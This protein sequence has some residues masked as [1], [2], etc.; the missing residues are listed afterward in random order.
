MYE[1]VDRQAAEAFVGHVCEETK[2]VRTHLFKSPGRQ[3]YWF[4]VTWLPGQLLLTGDLGCLSV[5]HYHALPSFEDAVK[6][7]RGACFEYMMEK[8]GVQRSYDRDAT[9]A[10]VNEMTREDA[11]LAQSIAE[12]AADFANEEFADR[13]LQDEL[14]E[15]GS[16]VEFF[17][18]VGL[19]DYYG[20]CRYPAQYRW[21]W[22]A[23][24]H[25]AEKVQP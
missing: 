23:L 4:R 20:T 22:H 12:Y 14:W 1:A 25:W 19:Q 11:D 21:Q 24:R 7:M 5:T 8:T 15:Q 2:L 18:R 17:G 6:W 10:A 3:E 9:L 16:A 13:W